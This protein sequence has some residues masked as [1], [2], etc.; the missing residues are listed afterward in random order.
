MNRVVEE[1][2]MD[3]KQGDKV[4]LTEKVRHEEYRGMT[5]YVNKVVKSRGV[6]VVLCENGKRYDAQPENVELIDN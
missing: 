3:V 1:V 2:E 4:R 5:G 6:V